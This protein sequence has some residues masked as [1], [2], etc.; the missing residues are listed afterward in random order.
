MYKS[1]LDKLSQLTDDEIDTS[2][3]P[4]LNDEQLARMKPLREVLPQAIPQQV[5]LTLRLDADIVQWF[6]NQAHQTGEDSYQALLNT[7]LRRYI[8]SREE[9]QA[10]AE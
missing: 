2:D 6:E 9:L 7:A 3:I 5:D 1:D 8:E 10:M 4:P